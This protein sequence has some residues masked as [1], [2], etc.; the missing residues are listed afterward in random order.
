MPVV[1]RGLVPVDANHSQAW[2]VVTQIESLLVGG[3]QAISERLGILE[4]QVPALGLFDHLQVRSAITSHAAILYLLLLSQHIESL[5][6]AHVSDVV[7]LRPQ[8]LVGERS[9]S[10]TM[11]MSRVSDNHVCGALSIWVLHHHVVLRRIHGCLVDVAAAV[12]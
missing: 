5:L 9:L 7:L 8:T 3:T 6:G 4:Q 2:I 1:E 12:E 10:I 11:G